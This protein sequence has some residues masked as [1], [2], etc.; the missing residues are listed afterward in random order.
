MLSHGLF[1]QAALGD[2]E[3]FLAL[4]NDAYQQYRQ[5]RGKATR[6]ETATSA[7]AKRAFAA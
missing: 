1:K 2:G 3:N 5:A 6:K 4:T 7:H